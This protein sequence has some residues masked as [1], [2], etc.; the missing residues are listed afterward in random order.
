MRVAYRI[1]HGID[2]PI[3]PKEGRESLQFS[4]D[5]RLGDWFMFKDYKMI[6]I[7]G[8]EGE[9][10]MLPVLLTIRILSMEYVSKRLL[11]YELHFRNFRK[12]ITFHIPKDVFPFQKKSLSSLQYMEAFLD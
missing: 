12:H 2:L 5:T 8:F 1:I 3:M 7:Y 11:Y 4:L 9:P 10:Y 6:I